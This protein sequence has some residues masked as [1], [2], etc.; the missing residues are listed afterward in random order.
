MASGGFTLIPDTA[1]L[2]TRKPRTKILWLKI[3]NHTKKSTL[4]IL[5]SRVW[6]FWLK[7]QNRRILV[8]SLAV[9]LNQFLVVCFSLPRPSTFLWPAEMGLEMMHSCHIL[10]FQPILWNR[11]FLSKPAKTAQNSSKSISEGGRICHLCISQTKL[12]PHNPRPYDINFFSS[13]WGLALG[14]LMRHLFHIFRFEMRTLCG[15]RSCGL[16]FFWVRQ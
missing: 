5:R 7:L 4:F 3:L 9:A 16:N 10:P 2:Q 8:W 14:W 11:H 6:S 15:G 1:K 13:A 12:S